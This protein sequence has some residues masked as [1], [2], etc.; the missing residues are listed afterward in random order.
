MRKENSELRTGFVSEA[1][2]YLQNHDFFTFTEF[3][4]F[5]CYI[6]ADGIDDD[7]SLSAEAAV[8][9]IMRVFMAKPSMKTGKLMDLLESANELLVKK[10]K[11]TVLE[12]SV[13]VIVTD[14]AKYRYAQ[15]GNVRL[16]HIRNGAVLYE[17]KDMSLA[18]ALADKGELAQDKIS[19]HE[20]RHNLSCYLGQ[21]AS[22]FLPFVSGKHKLEDGDILALYTRGVWEKLG[23]Q[24]LLESSEGAAEPEAWVNAVEGL[25]LAPTDKPIENYSFASIFVDKI[26]ENAENRKKLVKKILMIGIP[27]LVIL[28]AIGITLFVRHNIRQADITTMNDAFTDAKAAVEINNFARASEKAD[29]AYALAQKLK[30]PDEKQELLD[31][32]ILLSRIIAGDEAVRTGDYAKAYDEFRAAEEKSYYVDLQAT[33]YIDAKIKLSSDHTELLNLL[34]RGDAALDDGR[35]EAAEQYYTEART[36]A[37]ELRAAD[38]K[39]R[40]RDGIEAARALAAEQRATDLKAEAQGREQRGDENPEIAMEEYLRAAE[41]YKQAGDTAAEGFLRGKIDQIAADTA[42]ETE[43]TAVA[44][45]QAAELNGD[46]ALG[47]HD[48]VLAREQYMSAQSIYIDYG[49]TDP[50]QEIAQKLM[51]LFSA[52]QGGAEE[53]ERAAGYMRDGDANFVKGENAVARLLYQ[54]ARDI[55]QNLG[56][57]EDM[58]KAQTK[59]DQVDK[60]ISESGR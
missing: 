26:Y 40:A 52:E 45:A 35:P 8:R 54:T 46:M 30:L 23:V 21:R 55:Y 44:R 7:P 60:R 2:T 11:D 48:Y 3:E 5:A 47:A 56:L 17:S 49:M 34:D 59:M 4:N 28:L 1:G 27:I 42:A 57:L 12:V 41:L 38:E 58:E 29:E 53:L 18:S 19:E 37:A 10:S 32:T 14:Y 43:N 33:A 13:T 9:E 20:E 51:R 31:L 15:A 39:Q 6:L 22:R 36:L 50:A 24:D 25:V 16:C